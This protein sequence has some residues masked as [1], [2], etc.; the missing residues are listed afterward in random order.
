MAVTMLSVEVPVHAA[1]SLLGTAR[2]HFS[3][4]LTAVG[5]DRPIWETDAAELAD[6]SPADLLWQSLCRLHG[7]GPV[8]A[9]KL[10]AAKRPSLIPIYDQ[11]V[12]AA[13]GYPPG[14]FWAGMRMAMQDAHEAVA[15]VV[16]VAGVAVTPLRAVDIVVWMH[17]HGAQDRLPPPP[18]FD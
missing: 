10:M 18:P 4:L 11:H 13:L 2:D 15:E 1:I 7:V 8:T 17:Q 5:P 14:R 16:A 3:G 9:G 6:G 12:D